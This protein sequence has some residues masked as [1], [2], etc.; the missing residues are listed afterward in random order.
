MLALVLAE[1]NTQA[2]SILLFT[3]VALVTLTLLVLRNKT[4][5]NASKI[6]SKSNMGL[7]EL[8][9]GD[10]PTIEFVLLPMHSFN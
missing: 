2:R 5:Q 6:V 4:S 3:L 1:L 8:A 9:S 10:S 7:L